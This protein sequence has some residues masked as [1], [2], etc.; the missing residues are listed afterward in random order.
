MTIW[1]YN[2]P[3]Q[4]NEIQK[5]KPTHAKL[6]IK[7]IFFTPTAITKRTIHIRTFHIF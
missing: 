7:F 5:L 1:N 6:K 3:L 2:K 4:T